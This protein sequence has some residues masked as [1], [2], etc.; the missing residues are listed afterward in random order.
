M[1]VGRIL[2]ITFST[3]SLYIY[4]RFSI[5]VLFI[6]S[7]ISFLCNKRSATEVHFNKIVLDD[8]RINDQVSRNLFL[9]IIRLGF[10]L[11]IN[12]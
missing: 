10:E 3:L 2:D 1:T 11:K 8:C 4:V 9:C 12:L 5:F 6:Y 7:S